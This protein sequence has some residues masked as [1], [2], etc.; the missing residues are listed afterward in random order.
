MSF[1]ILT[2]PAAILLTALGLNAAR[3]EEFDT[4]STPVPYGDLDLSRPADAQIMAARLEDA[5]KSVCLKANP[6]AA[7]AF[8]QMCADAAISVAMT[9]MQDQMESAVDAKLDVIRASF[10]GP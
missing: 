3:A 10:A 6:D 1:R 7:P 8:I 5:A 2:A 4:V 9:Q